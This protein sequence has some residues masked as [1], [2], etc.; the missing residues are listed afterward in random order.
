MIKKLMNWLFFS[1]QHATEFV[2]KREFVSLSLMEKIRFKGHVT[3]CKACRS[4]ERQSALLEKMIH[5]ITNLSI[6]K[7]E[8]LKMDDIIK[9][10]ILVKLKEE[11]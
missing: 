4:Y 3:M 8:T 1:C 2:E 10:K 11:S 7:Q 6:S 9:A 5:Y